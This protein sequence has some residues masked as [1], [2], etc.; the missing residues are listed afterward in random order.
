MSLS[1]S[2]K[3]KPNYSYN[4]LRKQI[5]LNKN[6]MAGIQVGQAVVK[7][8]PA[9]K[10]EE[11][12]IFGIIHIDVPPEYFL[13]RFRDIKRCESIMGFYNAAFVT[14]ALLSDTSELARRRMI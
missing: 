1:A 10:K 9:E 11:I 13:A 7:S 4:F 6:Q 5:R 14:L 12:A 2:Q 3:Q 8:L